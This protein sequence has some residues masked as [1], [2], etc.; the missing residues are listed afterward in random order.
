M[1]VYITMLVNS[2]QLFK[3]LRTLKE[4][5]PW[6]S[7]KGSEGYLAATYPTVGQTSPRARKSMSLDMG[8]PSQANTKK[9]L[10]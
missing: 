8:Q 5:Q 1:V 6:S 2:S 7:P 10:G 4:N 9:L 3:S